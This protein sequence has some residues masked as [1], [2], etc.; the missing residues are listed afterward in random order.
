MLRKSTNEDISDE[1]CEKV[2]NPFYD[3]HH[4]LVEEYIMTVY[5]DPRSS[6]NEKPWFFKVI[7]QDSFGNNRQKKSKNFA[8]K[9]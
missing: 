4:T 2:I 9:K 3:N 5:K 1:E 7:Y 6:R 8:T